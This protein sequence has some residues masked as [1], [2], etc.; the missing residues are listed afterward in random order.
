MDKVLASG[1][2]LGNRISVEAFKQDGAITL[3]VDGVQQ[4][5]IQADFEQRL[6][7]AP[8]MGGTFY[9]EPDTLLA[10]FSVLEQS[11]FDKLHS[12]RVEGELEE[13]PNEENQIY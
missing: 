1:I 7:H 9:P 12:I 10:A 4:K 13:I 2:Y 3:L 11:F 8:A 5:E 6:N